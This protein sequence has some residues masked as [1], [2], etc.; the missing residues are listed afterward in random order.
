L[1]IR[2]GGKM[3]NTELRDRR[4]ALNLTQKDLARLLY[5]TPDCIAKWESGKYSIPKT[6]SSLL[7]SLAPLKNEV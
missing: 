6:L 5:R 4:K 1:R 3:T 2:I 7:D